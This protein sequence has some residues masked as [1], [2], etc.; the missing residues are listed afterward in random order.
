MQI[1]T[2]YSLVQIITLE[3]AASPFTGPQSSSYLKF[4]AHVIINIRRTVQDN[5]WPETLT[6]SVDLQAPE[7]H[8]CGYPSGKANVLEPWSKLRGH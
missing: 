4:K 8:R 5:Q 2:L 6:Y 7:M 3:D 1:A